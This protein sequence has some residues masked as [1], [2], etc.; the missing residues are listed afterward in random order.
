MDIWKI[1]KQQDSISVIWDILHLKN[2]FFLF[3]P[4][5]ND[6]IENIGM[7]LKTTH[8]IEEYSHIGL[9]VQVWQLSL[10]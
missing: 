9:P 4:V 10:S 7:E 8:D 2:V 6:L 5:L 3:W 1:M